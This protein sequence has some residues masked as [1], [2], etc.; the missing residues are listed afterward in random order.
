MLVDGEDGGDDA[1]HGVGKHAA[2]YYV[3]ED[4]H[5]RLGAN[6]AFE[7]RLMGVEQ[8]CDFLAKQAMLPIYFWGWCVVFRLYVGK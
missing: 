4:G 1:N 2:A 8:A 7:A 6:A 5:V 3:V